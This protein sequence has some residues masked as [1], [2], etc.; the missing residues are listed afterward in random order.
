MDA[1]KKTLSKTLEEE[2]IDDIPES[3]ALQTMQIKYTDWKFRHAAILD[4][5]TPTPTVLYEID[6]KFRKPQLAFRLAS[7]ET[8]FATSSYHTLSTAIDVELRGQPVQLKVTSKWKQNAYTYSSP[9]FNGQTLTWKVKHGCKTSDWVCL[10]ERSLPIAR[11]SVNFLIWKEVGK[12]D[13]IGEFAEKQDMRD[14]VMAMAVT[15]AYLTVIRNAS[16]LSA[17]SAAAA[18]GGAAAAAAA[19]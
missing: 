8:P 7:D 13:I 2:Y 12:L 6:G 5:A 11:V 18:S 4:T 14:E 3:T 9:A 1:E 16:I 15:M 19:S 10:D 17:G